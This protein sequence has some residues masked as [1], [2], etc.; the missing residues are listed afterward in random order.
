[1]K[2]VLLTKEQFVKCM[3]HYKQVDDMMDE[4]S[5]AIGKLAPDSHAPIISEPCNTIGEVL[6]IVMDDFWGDIS[7]Y[8]WELD[9]GKD[10][11]DCVEHGGQ[12]YSLTTFEE[13][14]DWM[15]LDDRQ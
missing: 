6:K 4:F 7:Y 12:V 15:M 10:G 5:L 14:Y 13:L 2:K 9:W 1:M 8:A 3:E 11:K